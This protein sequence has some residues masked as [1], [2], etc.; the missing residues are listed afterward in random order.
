[1][2]QMVWNFVN[3]SL[4]TTVCLQWEPEIIAVAMIHLASKLSKFIVDDWD[5]RR[6]NHLRWWDM[7]V[8]DITME[9]L[10]DICHQVSILII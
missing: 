7:F 6:Q 2:V 10:E 8:A 9:I 5:G 3:D 4:S 1:M